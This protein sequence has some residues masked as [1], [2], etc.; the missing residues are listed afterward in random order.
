MT[1]LL[2]I[3]VHAQEYV[4][5]NIDLTI[6]ENYKKINTGEELLTSIKLLNLASTGRIDVILQ[7]Q[8][9]N[10]SNEI[11][12]TKQETVAIETQAN[13]VRT[14]KIPKDSE[15]GKYVLHAKMILPNEREVTTKESF[16]VEN[17]K[18]KITQIIA[19]TTTLLILTIL[20]IINSKKHLK[21]YKLK[22]RIKRI[23]KNKITQNKEK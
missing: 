5:S 23:I 15:P 16:H 7:F 20:L 14:F 12:Y 21:N 8:I 18:Q 2:S 13:F 6:P 17:K 4:S 9:T 11:I 19:I 1:L 22:R 3:T 10:P